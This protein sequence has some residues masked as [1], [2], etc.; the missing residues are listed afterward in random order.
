[1]PLPSKSKKS[2]FKIKTIKPLALQNICF[3][4]QET[5]TSQNALVPGVHSNKAR[6]STPNLQ[7]SKSL[8][9]VHRT[10]VKINEAHQLSESSQR[11]D[12][13]DSGFRT[14]DPTALQ[15]NLFSKL[16]N[17]LNQRASPLVGAQPALPPL[18][19]SKPAG[20]SHHHLV[21]AKQLKK[22]QRSQSVNSKQDTLGGR[23][24]S[25]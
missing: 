7:F 6:D 3:A 16:T 18:G 20:S 13:H 5:R 2:K 10:D 8:K 4:E 19:N 12:L 15:K 9:Y 1:M 25:Y 17:N 24:Q 21:Q 11:E 14:M 23:S 22:Q